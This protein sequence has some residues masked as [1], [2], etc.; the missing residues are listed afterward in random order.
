MD[1]DIF[2]DGVA[3]PVKSGGAKAVE[4]KSMTVAEKSKDIST[5]K[6][7]QKKDVKELRRRT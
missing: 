5:N 4:D 2:F 7:D 3:D 6:K 1:D